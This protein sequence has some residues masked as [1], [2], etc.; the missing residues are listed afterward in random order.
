MKKSS[1]VYTRFAALLI[2]VGAI[3]AADAHLELSVIKKFWPVFVTIFSIG[4]FGIFYQTRPRGGIYL[5]LGIYLLG[6]SGMA[7]YCNFTSWAAM[8]SIWPVFISLLGVVFVAMSIAKSKG[9]RFNLITGLFIL[10][11]SITLFLVFTH[12]REYWWSALVL[13]GLSILITEKAK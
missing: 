13:L 4:L 3:A 5:V 10:S 12:G 8:K 2:V 7:F 6:F 1:S 9:R 11:V